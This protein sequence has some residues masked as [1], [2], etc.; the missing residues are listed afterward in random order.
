[1]AQS[2]KLGREVDHEGRKWK[3]IEDYRRQLFPTVFVLCSI[4]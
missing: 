2:E 1:M 3:A 4:Y